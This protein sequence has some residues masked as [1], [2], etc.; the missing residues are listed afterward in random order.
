MFSQATMK[1]AF[2][3]QSLLGISNLIA[4][5]ENFRDYFIDRGIYTELIKR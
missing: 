4:L 3:E 1:I 2:L 5:C